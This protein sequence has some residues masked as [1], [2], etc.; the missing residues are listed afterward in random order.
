M[1]MVKIRTINQNG[2]LGISIPKEIE[3]Q[4]N[5]ANGNDVGFY[6]QPPEVIDPKTMLVLQF[7]ESPKIIF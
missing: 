5:L 3:V 7:K 4:F 1:K 6:K 2:A